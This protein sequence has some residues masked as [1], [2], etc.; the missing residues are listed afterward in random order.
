MKKYSRKTGILRFHTSDLCI[1]KRIYLCIL[2]IYIFV[3][4]IYI[5]IYLYITHLN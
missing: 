4:I 5:F 3:S 1:H 2:Y